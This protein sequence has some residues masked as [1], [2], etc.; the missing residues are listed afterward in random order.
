MNHTP[1][2]P[3]NDHALPDFLSPSSHYYEDIEFHKKN[4]IYIVVSG[5]VLLL[6]VIHLINWDK[7]ALQIIPLKIKTSLGVASRSDFQTLARVCE[8]RLKYDCAVD[9]LSIAAQHQGSITEFITIA[10]LYRKMS[11]F[12]KAIRYYNWA[13]EAVTPITGDATSLLAEIHYGLAKP[14]EAMGQTDQA[15]SH[16]DLALKS[17][18]EVIQITITQDYLNLLRYLGKK[19]VAIAVVLEARKRGGSERLFADTTESM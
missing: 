11:Q 2:N 18:P 5:L 7:H 13:L 1:N 12:S 3:Q 19:E 17:K 8:N 14:N 4:L 6:A 10:N 9:A 15:L 16:Y